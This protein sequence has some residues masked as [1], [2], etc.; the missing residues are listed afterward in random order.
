MATKFHLIRT[1]T[2]EISSSSLTEIVAFTMAD[3][4]TIQVIGNVVGQAQV[5]DCAGFIIRAVFK[6]RAGGAP[7][8]VGTQ[9]LTIW[10]KKDDNGFWAAE[11]VVTGNDITISASGEDD[12]AADWY[13]TMEI[14]GFTP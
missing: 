9:D 8:L 13:A 1:A 3:D 5:T 12:V 6:R 11:F 14:F 4:T 2:R 7:T 10:P